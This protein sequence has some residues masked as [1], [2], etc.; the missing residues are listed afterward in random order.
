MQKL[1]LAHGGGGEGYFKKWFQISLYL[2]VN[3]NFTSL[4]HL[5]S[6]TDFT[7]IKHSGQGSFKVKKRTIDK[8]LFFTENHIVGEPKSRIVQKHTFFAPERY[9]AGILYTDSLNSA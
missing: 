3:Q 8:L 5:I 6:K 7:A 1:L 9:T 4:K 2:N